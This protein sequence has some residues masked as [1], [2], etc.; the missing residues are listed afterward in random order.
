MRPD[1]HIA[2]LGGQ[3]SAA[4]ADA[5]MDAVLRRG[6]LDDSGYRITSESIQVNGELK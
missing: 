4:E 5:V 1:Q 6:L 3:L 2:W